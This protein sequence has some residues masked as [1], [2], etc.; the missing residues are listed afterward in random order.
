MEKKKNYSFIEGWVSIIMNILL[1]VI[2][3]YAGIVT[4]SIAL[5]ADA[6]HTLSD[7]FSSLIVIFGAKFSLKPADEGHPYGHGRA[8]LIA[9]LI[10]GV[11]LSIVAF[12]FISDSV[13]RLMDKESVQYGEVAVIV[14]IVSVIVKEGL[15]QFAFWAAKQQSSQ[16]LRADAWHHRS[17]AIS[18]VVILAGIVLQDVFW[19]MDGILGI[20][21]GILIF[22]TS[23][24]VLRDAIDPLMGKDIDGATKLKLEKICREIGG[25]KIMAHHYHLHEYGDH[26]ELT[27]HIKLPNEMN[28]E[29]AHDVATRIEEKIKI[30][31]MIETT[32]HMEP[33]EE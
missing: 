33:R 9:S 20:L 15:A 30:S 1:F 27:F 11:M 7:S 13:S 19:G 24:E 3:Y 32:I 28:L 10:M 21:V 17:D 2:K 5:I 4:G 31:L 16:T 12:S 6:W 29:D 18:S 23:Y 8:E 14:T 25:E 22:Y 26:R